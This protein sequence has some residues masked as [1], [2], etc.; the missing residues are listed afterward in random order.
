M[1]NKIVRTLLEEGI[2][3]HWL[4]VEAKLINPLLP[5]YQDWL[6]KMVPDANK[7]HKKG[8]N[9]PAVAKLLLKFLCYRLE[10]EL[11]RMVFLRDKYNEFS[12]RYSK[13]INFK[14]KR[15]DILDFAKILGAGWWQLWG[16]ERA[17][18]RW[19]G[20]DAIV[21]R[22]QRMQTM[23]ARRLTFFLKRIGVLASIV[24]KKYGNWESLELETHLKPLLNYNGDSR[25][26]LEAFCCLS[27]IFKN[28]KIQ[29]NDLTA[30]TLQQIYRASI[31]NQQNV[32]IQSEALNLLGCLSSQSLQGVLQKRFTE[33][34]DG[35]DLF[36]RRRAVDLLG[37]NSQ[38]FELFPVVIK[39][40]SP[41]V[42]QA[43]AK[44]LRTAPIDIVQIYLRQLVCE[45]K[46]ASVRAA[47][48]LEIPFFL[49]QSDFE[50]FLLELLSECLTNETDNF[51]IRVAL[52]VAT[53]TCEN[54][55]EQ[56]A[57][58]LLQNIEKI[59]ISPDKP[60]ETRRWAAQAAERI[61][62][63]LVQDA[64]IL[65]KYLEDKLGPEQRQYLKPLQV[66]D[67][68]L[69]RVL[70]VMCQEDFGYD[71]KQNWFNKTIIRGHLFGFRL[72]RLI[73]E[74]RNPDP[75]KRQAFQHTVGRYF[76]GQLHIPSGILSE[77]AET[78]VPGEPLFMATEGGWRPYLPLVDELIDC[79]RRPVV[80]IYTSE[81]ITTLNPPKTLFKRLQARWKLTW[82]FSHYAH[83]RN[84]KEQSQS[85]ASTYIEALQSLGFKIIYQNHP[86]FKADPAVERFFPMILPFFTMNDVKEFWARFQEY[87]FSVYQN[88]LQDLLIFAAGALGYFFTRHWYANHLLNRTRANIPLIIGGWGTRG[89]SGTERIKAA[90][91][92][93]LG[94][95]V[96]SKT[97][98][99][100]AMFLHASAFEPTHEMFLFRHYDKATIW[101]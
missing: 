25:V 68:T 42:R 58:L 21:E 99:C 87:F 93:A 48:L 70:S 28:F 30:Y 4:K 38:L 79:L 91:F 34:G 45:D 49:A 18:S 41:F 84:W 69:A 61:W 5:E 76:P 9:R 62:C 29:E 54:G 96:F 73:H 12:K 63:Y 85:P 74:F 51:V 8:D 44:A 23:S 17:F 66:N 86:E 82:R 60:L 27:T 16:D 95:S 90:M 53:D 52:K 94:Y 24:L 81:G 65:R 80:K 32:W 56:W 46:I 88:T 10:Q 92:N 98:G 75:S 6:V 64:R 78:K 72:W 40:H 50:A 15:Q 11:T 39:D 83:L 26:R 35:D 47:A 55:S 13:A 33:P 89:K 100:E 37:R 36:V 7:N 31:D 14:E 20:Q 77:L 101:E 2:H 59:H 1:T 3:P 71:V 57:E 67:M 97:T 22:Y 19:F 43:L